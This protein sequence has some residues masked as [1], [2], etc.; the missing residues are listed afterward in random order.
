MELTVPPSPLAMRMTVRNT[1]LEIDEFD[2]GALEHSPF[3]RQSTEPT[4]PSAELYKSWKQ[5]SKDAGLPTK[6]G[7]FKPQVSEGSTQDPPQCNE[8]TAGM[9]LCSN[10]SME[11]MPKEYIPSS[12]N[13]SFG[14]PVPQSQA[15]AQ[16]QVVTE[17]PP[18]NVERT[19]PCE[20]LKLC[21]LGPTNSNVVQ[22]DVISFCPSCGNKAMAT[23]RFC[24]FCRFELRPEERRQM[25]SAQASF[26]QQASVPMAAGRVAQLP[27][28]HTSVLSVVGCMLYQEAPKHVVDHMIQ[29]YY[30][31]LCYA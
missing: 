20:V 14:S 21:N 12:Y 1:F 18:R 17:S 27:P 26:G 9:D 8:Y 30:S 22:H 19:N 6:D 7:G 25:A 28:Q 5:E 4:K 11:D 24:P 29:V 2:P 16:Q 10:S 31:K 3:R 13:P 23:H 15:L